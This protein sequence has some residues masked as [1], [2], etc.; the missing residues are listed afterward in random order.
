M[1]AGEMFWGGSARTARTSSEI[2]IS[3]MK[4]PLNQMPPSPADD[5]SGEMN[6]S[7]I[8]FRQLVIP[9][10]KLTESVE[11]GMSAFN[12]PTSVLRGTPSCALFSCDPRAIAPGAESVREPARRRIPY[13]RTRIVAFFR[14]GQ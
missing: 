8:A 6:E 9:D 13:P 12:D 4:L 7:L 11:P 5:C 14:E 1:K 3:Q 10:Q 2:V